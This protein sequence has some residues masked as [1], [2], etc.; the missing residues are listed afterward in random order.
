LENYLCWCLHWINKM[1]HIRIF[2][3]ICCSV[4]GFFKFIITC[5]EKCWYLVNAYNQN[6]LNLF[7]F[8]FLFIYYELNNTML[9]NIISPLL[10]TKFQFATLYGCS[11]ESTSSIISWTGAICSSW[12]TFIAW[13][14]GSS[15]FD[16]SPATF[17]GPV[18]KK[19]IT[20]NV[21]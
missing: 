1:K 21:T 7:C 6:K 10:Y 11:F 5:F 16:Y 4:N 17:T 18:L 12:I 20:I 3:I 13:N 9:V 15:R 8:F 2:Q 19:I 14:T